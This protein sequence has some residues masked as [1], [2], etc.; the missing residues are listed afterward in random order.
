MPST[1]N[2]DYQHFEFIT[3]S[4]RRLEIWGDLVSFQ[5][6]IETGVVEHLILKREGAIHQ[7]P[8]VPPRKFSYRCVMIG[9]N[10]GDR[11]RALA[12]AISEDPTGRLIDPRFGS[13]RA[14]CLDL[15][16]QEDPEQATDRV[17]YSLSFAESGLRTSPR[18]NAASIAARAQAQA[19]QFVTIAPASFAT[20]AGALRSAVG[21]LT[22]LIATAVSLPQVLEARRA[23][24]DVVAQAEAARTAAKSQGLYDAGAQAALIRSAAQEAVDRLDAQRPRTKQHYVPADTSLARLCAALYGGPT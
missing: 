18:E 21:V 22:S 23:M 4:L 7:R 10:V 15:T 20:Y 1:V 24:G 6:R 2:Q 12:D 17:T 8:V 11:Y 16:Q 13:A 9:A 3:N 14:V 5:H 19:D